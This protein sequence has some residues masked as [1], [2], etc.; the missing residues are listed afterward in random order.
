MIP[1][2]VSRGLSAFCVRGHEPHEPLSHLTQE[3]RLVQLILRIAVGGRDLQHEAVD[4]VD[5]NGDDV[6]HST[7]RLELSPG[8]SGLDDPAQRISPGVLSPFDI[9]LELWMPSRRGARLYPD[10]ASMVISNGAIEER[11]ELSVCVLVVASEL[12]P[13]GCSPYARGAD[14]LSQQF[15]A[16]D[17]VVLDHA[18]RHTGLPRDVAQAQCVEAMKREEPFSCSEDQA[19]ALLSDLVKRSSLSW[20]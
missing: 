19:S 7:T 9:G 14:R 6:G 2:L 17:E 4:Q 15:V 11:S 10:D 1:G 20:H 18:D 13:L 16:R 12:F 8:Y 3:P 5:E